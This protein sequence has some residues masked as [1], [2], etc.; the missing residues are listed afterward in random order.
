MGGSDESAAVTE[1]ETAAETAARMREAVSA[2][3]AVLEPEQVRELRAGP[4]RLDAPELRE[5]KYVPGPRPGLSTEDLDGD[6]RAA[7]DALL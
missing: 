5:W 4:A 3:L 6:Q 1:E 7:V 2:L